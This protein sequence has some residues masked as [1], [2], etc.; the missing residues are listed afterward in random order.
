M[1]TC[2]ST[3]LPFQ[4]GVRLKNIWLRNVDVEQDIV[5]ASCFKQP[6]VL[7]TVAVMIFGPHP[8]SEATLYCVRFGEASCSGDKPTLWHASWLQEPIDK[9]VRVAVV[10]CTFL[11]FEGRLCRDL[12]ILF[13]CEMHSQH[14][15]V[16]ACWSWKIASPFRRISIKSWLRG[17]KA[18]SR[19]CC[20]QRWVLKDFAKA[21]LLI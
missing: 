19:T 1:I 18:L 16:V 11:L 6:F 21:F 2:F 12:P 4:K 15:S 9:D 17:G 8:D 20:M 10:L 5:I 13:R 7:Q 3:Q 14:D